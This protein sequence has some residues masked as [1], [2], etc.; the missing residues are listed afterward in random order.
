MD[1]KFDY[2]VIGGGVSGLHLGALLSQHGG[3]LLLE[4]SGS[5]GGR[6]RVIEKEGF[7]LDYGIHLIRFGPES[8]LGASLLEVGKSI[9]FIKPGKSWAFLQSGARELFPAGG[10]MDVIRSRLVPFQK[11]IRLLL[12]IKKMKEEELQKMYNISLNEWFKKENIPL[13]IQKYLTM[14]S[15]AIQVNPFP[16]RS[17]A[18]ELL[19]NIQRVLERGSAYYPRGGWEPILTQFTDTINENGG[20]IKLTSK[21]DGILVEH[22]VC[23]GVKIDEKAI[24]GKE[25]ISTIPVQNLFTI[26]DENHCNPSFVAECKN[27]RPTAG[28]AIDFCLGESISDIDGLIFFEKPLGFGMITSNLSPEICPKGKSLMTFLTV[29]DVKEIENK[30]NAKQ[31][32]KE[33][34]NEIIKHFPRIEDHLIYERSLYLQVVDGVEVNVNQHQFKRPGH[35]IEGVDHLWLAGDNVGGEGAGGDVGHT[36]VRECYKLIKEVK[37]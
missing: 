4:K 22:G 33:F 23:K 15:S 13:Q 10:L 30:T 7:K 19:H 8:A 24:Y 28:V 2:I 37:K 36:S 27:L 17:S 25:T 1:K 26:L 5:L 29:T 12:Q 3:V 21:V 6:A 11:T 16:E 18:G 35:I 34:R 14:T 32:Y 20:K 9:R 31:I